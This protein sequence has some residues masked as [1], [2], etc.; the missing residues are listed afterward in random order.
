MELYL[1]RE[2]ALQAFQCDIQSGT[3]KRAFGHEK[4]GRFQEQK[5]GILMGNSGLEK[6]HFLKA[7]IVAFL[8]PPSRQNN[9]ES[10]S[11]KQQKTRGT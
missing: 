10:R 11:T 7:K 4:S 3:E 1:K 6:R 5:P 9:H 8:E 2:M